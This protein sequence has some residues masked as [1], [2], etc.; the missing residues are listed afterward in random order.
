ME[1][2]KKVSEYTIYKKRSG[3]YAVRDA[4]RNWV[5]EAAKIEILL[6]EGLIV[7]PVPTVKITDAEADQPASDGQGSTR[8]VEETE[9]EAVESEPEASEPE[10]ESE[11]EAEPEADAESEAADN[12]QKEGSE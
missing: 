1:V 3:R 10:A 8:D 2:V 7:A 11:G 12:E 4:Y 5:N 9:A 6:A